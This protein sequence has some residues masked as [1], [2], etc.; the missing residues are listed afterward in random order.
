MIYK[1][2][3]PRHKTTRPLFQ[4]LEENQPMCSAVLEGVYPGKVFVD[5]LDHPKTAFLSGFI[6]SEDE[7][8]WGF[9]AGKARNDLF[10]N[11][12]NKAILNREII[13]ERAPIVFFTCHPDDWQGQLP[14]VCHPQQPIPSLRRHYEC[15][16]FKFDGHDD[17][18]E[19]YDIQP[20][21]ETLL[22]LPDLSIPDDVVR[23]IRK[24]RSLS[25]SRLK[26]FGFVAIYNKQVV[27]WATVDFV[28]GG[29]GD[30]GLFTAEGHRRRGLATVVTASALKH[31]LSYGLSKIHWTCAETNIAS[32]RTAEKLG[33]ERGRDYTMYCWIFDEVQHLGNLAYS[34]L[35]GERY[36]DAV[37]IFEKMFVMK[38]DLPLWVYYD[39]A[40]AWAGLGNQEKMFTYLNTLAEKG[41][42]EIESL[43]RC[44]EFEQWR[45]KREWETLLERMQGTGQEKPTG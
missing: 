6:S 44:K 41:W 32:I 38:K 12:L 34:H 5:D 21:D 37:D 17:I 26:D 40:R 20:L 25:D 2:D 11:A 45:E 28:S 13:S 1:L 16:S 4:P 35:Q 39:T 8:V 19:G 43:E 3:P 22:T 24:W 7:G 14:I 9:L 23:I 36:R 42:T 31:G 15:R 33:L 29:V 10:N 18:P 27:S 30:A